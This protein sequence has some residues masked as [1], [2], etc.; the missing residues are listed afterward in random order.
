MLNNSNLSEAYIAFVEQNSEVIYHN[1]NNYKLK[2]KS[3][4]CEETSKNS[5]Q[6]INKNGE[7]T[8]KNI[9]EVIM[10]TAC[11]LFMDSSVSQVIQAYK[12]MIDGK[13]IHA[14]P[15]LINSCTLYNQLS[16]CFLAYIGDSLLDILN[17]AKNSGF[18]SKHC[19]GIGLTLSEL[20]SKNSVINST[21]RPSDGIFSYIKI[22]YNVQKAA[23]Q[24]GRRKGAFALFLDICHPEI[25]MFI[26]LKRT[27]DTI[28]VDNNENLK[29][30][31]VGIMIN[32]VFIEL[33][34]GYKKYGKD[35]YLYLFNPA[36]YPFLNNTYGIEFKQIYYDNVSNNKY[37]DKIKISELEK[38]LVY[39]I[40]ESGTPYILSKDNINRQSNMQNIGT[41][42]GSNLCAEITVPSKCYKK[43]NRNESIKIPD[44]F[45]DPVAQSEFMRH[46]MNNICDNINKDEYGVCNL[47]SI[48]LSSYVNDGQ[49]DFQEL[50][51]ISEQLVV[52][53][54]KVID[55]SY[56]PVIEATNSDFKYRPL[57][58]GVQ[59]L[60]GAFIK[61]G[62]PYDSVE[63]KELNF[64]ISA[65]IYY[66][67]MNKSSE[68]GKLYGNYTGFYNSPANLGQLQPDLY[69]KNLKEL[70]YL[71]VDQNGFH[72]S[73]ETIDD[74][75]MDKLAKIT[76]NYLT[77]E[78]WNN[79]RKKC[80]KHLRNAY[81]TA[82]MPTFTTSNIFGSTESFEPPSSLYYYKS[83]PRIG[84]VLVINKHL[85]NDLKKNNIELKDIEYELK[86][87][88]SLQNID[89]IPDNLKRIY[90][91]AYEIDDSVLMQHSILR[92]PFTSQSQSFNHFFNKSINNTDVSK[93]ILY[94]YLGGLN[95]I[96]YYCR[97]RAAISGA[98]L[99]CNKNGECLSCT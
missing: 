11:Q 53:I 76:N 49:F 41:I 37:T 65:I 99:V 44:N 35:N 90:K 33:Y 88:G 36:D 15:T 42:L 97:Q 51:R 94:G 64:A 14:S 70:S 47:A 93:I 30:M 66:H 18:I 24:G 59:D 80:S 31:N 27:K 20:R 25:K 96:S 43:N 19:G 50:G 22:Y 10:R 48:N 34:Y 74:N 78:D 72:K 55:V 54:N 23:N 39:A 46:Y 7:E 12:D 71:N 67:A 86:T 21:G 81:V 85:E 79:L 69:L 84:D 26:E 82:Y 89:I 56:K 40:S 16:S 57:G 75:W 1:L 6:L 83:N 92:M 38:L 28:Y 9:E 13:Y 52:N 61:M 73:Y 17:V 68:L 60:S 58:I 8:E 45:A 87:T 29:S 4:I 91:T 98:S 32:D 77:K 2:N 95:T 62:Y 3:L 5:Y 63:A